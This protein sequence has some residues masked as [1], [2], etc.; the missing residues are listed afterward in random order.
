MAPGCS[1]IPNCDSASSAGPVLVEVDGRVLNRSTQGCS[2]WPAAAGIGRRGINPPT[3]FDLEVMRAQLGPSARV[4]MPIRTDVYVVGRV[5]RARRGRDA[6]HS[7]QD[8]PAV[9]P[10]PDG[11]PPAIVYYHGA[12]G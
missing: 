3:V 12:D 8:L 6:R 10:R 4:A 2:S 5:I 11:H 7:G 1:R 9:R